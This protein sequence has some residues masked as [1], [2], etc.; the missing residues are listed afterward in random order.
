MP[1]LILNNNTHNRVFMQVTVRVDKRERAHI[2]A[3]IEKNIFASYGHCLRALL[4]YYTVHTKEIAQ[5]RAENARLKERL[6]LVSEG[7][8]D[9]K[10]AFA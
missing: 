3:L 5:L 8:L 9:A 1:H 7:K 4:H 6:R 2:D 10:K